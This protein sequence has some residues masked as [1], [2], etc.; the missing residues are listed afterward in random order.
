MQIMS[1]N[2]ISVQVCTYWLLYLNILPLEFMKIV[3]ALLWFVFS[4]KYNLVT[5][6]N[7]ETI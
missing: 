4:I 7:T 2:T 3:Y 1:I 5:R 6:Q